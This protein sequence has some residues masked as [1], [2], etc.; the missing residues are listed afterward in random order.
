VNEALDVSCLQV[1][2]WGHLGVIGGAVRAPSFPLAELYMSQ[3]RLL[4][5]T[6]AVVIPL[7]RCDPRRP[8]HHRR[9]HA[10]NMTYAQDLHGKIACVFLLTRDYALEW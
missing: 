6:R 9:T 2:L 8:R 1:V 7:P 4:G 10:A 3:L 5:R